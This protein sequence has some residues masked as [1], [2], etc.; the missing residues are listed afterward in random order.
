M[1]S[2]K[3]VLKFVTGTFQCVKGA[4]VSRQSGPVVSPRLG[5]VMREVRPAPRARNVFAGFRVCC[6]AAGL[7]GALPV[8]TGSGAQNLPASYED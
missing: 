7:W 3:N 6:S 8:A 4:G 2:W 5:W 1:G